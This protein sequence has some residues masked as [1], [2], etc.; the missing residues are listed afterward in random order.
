MNCV[1]LIIAGCTFTKDFCCGLKRQR[2][3]GEL[4][5]SFDEAI[6]GSGEGVVEG[7]E[8]RSLID[9]GI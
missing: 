6:P 1:P 9:T 7:V 2:E 3:R 8:G 5:M 4:A